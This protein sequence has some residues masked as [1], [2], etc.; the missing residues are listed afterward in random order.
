[1]QPENRSILLE[2][3]IR[4]LFHSIM[5][6]SLYLLFAGHNLPGGG[7]AGGLV[8]GMGLVMRYIAG[9]RWELG[10]AAPTDA[11]RLLG[12]GMAIAVLCALAPNI[13]LFLAA[14]AAMGS[15]NAF[16]SPILL[17]ALSEVAAPEVLGRTVGTFAAAQTAGLMLAPI[18]GGLLGEISWRLAFVLVAV[19]AGVLAFPSQTLGAA[20][21][22]TPSSR[23]SL[24]SLLN[25]WIALLATQAALARFIDEGRLARHIRVATR[26]YGRRYARIADVLGRRFPRWL[27]VVPAMAGMHLTATVAPDAAV[28]VADVV[29]RAQQRGVIVRRLAD[30]HLATA[31]TDGLVLG[32]GG[33]PAARIDEGL[34][35]L[36]GA[37]GAAA[38]VPGT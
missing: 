12:A 15:A 1:M 22:S 32:F 20:E 38:A 10:A 2:I 31:T 19:V 34:A 14:R 24:R 4:V 6:V 28:D 13:W 23:A 26:E 27:R 21:R 25:R 8:A 33:I 18:L 35:R 7:F 30:F 3:V 5:I 37:F 29:R 9:G 16:L 11:G 17:A 36:A